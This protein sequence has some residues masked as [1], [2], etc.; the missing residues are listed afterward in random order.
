MDNIKKSF[1]NFTQETSVSTIKELHKVPMGYAK[2]AQALRQVYTSLDFNKEGFFPTF[3]VKVQGDELTVLNLAPNL[4]V[5]KLIINQKYIQDRYDKKI[6]VLGAK[7][8][9][10]QGAFKVEIEDG[11]HKISLIIPYQ[12]VT[13]KISETT[14]I[15]E[16]IFTTLVNK[17]AKL[18]TYELV[19]QLYYQLKLPAMIFDDQGNCISKI[20][21]SLYYTWLN[22]SGK[23]GNKKAA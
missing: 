23:S 5:V 22:N 19:K 20:Y 17:E 16:T 12:L 7:T 13:Y 4:D 9:T 10:E 1:E 8:K 14:E 18:L 21:Q 15:S 3:R 6:I 11:A 2:I